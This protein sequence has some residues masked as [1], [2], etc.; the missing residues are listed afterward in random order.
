MSH[1]PRAADPARSQAPS[2]RLAGRLSSPGR[3]LATLGVEEGSAAAGR[4]RSAQA[5][6]PSGSPPAAFSEGNSSS[7]ARIDPAGGCPDRPPAAAAADRPRPGAGWPRLRVGREQRDRAGDRLQLRARIGRAAGTRSTSS[8][9]TRIP[10]PAQASAKLA[11]RLASAALARLVGRDR[12]RVALGRAGRA[13]VIMVPGQ[14]VALHQLGRAPHQAER[15]PHVDRDAGGRAARPAA[16]AGR[17]RRDHAGAEDR[18]RRSGRTTSSALAI[19]A[20]QSSSLVEIGRLE[21]RPRSR[22]PR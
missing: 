22:P 6:G 20:A 5:A 3:R 19:S 8:P 16:P 2:D 11:V 18:A 4:R 1:P 10:S 9:S 21:L 12:Q 14:A 17:A 7:I 15:R 13:R